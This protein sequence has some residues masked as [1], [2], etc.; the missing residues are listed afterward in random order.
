[1]QLHRNAKLG[2][3]GRFA[4]VRANESGCLIREAARRH[5]LSPAT[6]CTWSRRW[7]EASE[8]ERKTLVCWYDRSSRPRRCPRMLAPAEQERICEARRR[9]G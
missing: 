1:M 3:S 9:T 2:L 7:R 5:G 6:A 8:N 4:L